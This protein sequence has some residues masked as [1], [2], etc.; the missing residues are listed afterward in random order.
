MNRLV[1]VLLALIVLAG[2]GAYLGGDSARGAVDASESAEELDPG[3]LRWLLRSRWWRQT[4]D[5]PAAPTLSDI[6]YDSLTVSWT[7]PESAVFEIVDYDVQYRTADA[8]GFVDWGHDGTATEATITGLAEDTEYRVRV[9]AVSDAGEGDWSETVGVTTLVRPPEFVEGESAEREVQENAAPG[10]AVGEP[11]TATVS[12]GAPRYSLEGPDAFAF[13]IDASSGQLLTR[14][15][16]TY[17]HEARD[18]YAVEVEARD[19]RGGTGRIAVRIE[20]LD[21]EEPPGKPGAPTVTAF[22]STGLQVTWTV[23]TNEG[24]ELSGYDVEYRA[25]GTEAYLDAEHEE[26]ATRA[27]I[28]GLARATLYEVRVRA[29]NDEGTGAW[30]DTAQ[31]RTPSA[32]GG[33]GGG[34]TSPPPPPPPPQNAAPI[35]TGARS[36]SVSENTLSVGRVMA[37]DPDNGDSISGYAITGGADRSRFSI[38]ATGNLRFTTARDFENPTD[39]FNASPRNAPRNNAYVLVVTATGGAGSRARTASRTITVAVSDTT[40][41]PATPAAPTIWSASSDS[42]T[43]RWTVPA[44]AGPL[45]RD[46]DVQYR[47][48]NSGNFDDWEHGGAGTVATI[49]GLAPSTSYQIQVLAR[50]DEGE[51]LWSLAGEGMTVDTVPTVLRVGLVSDAGPDATYKLGDKIQVAVTFSEA[52][53]VDATGGTPQI[54]LT[55]G[56]GSARQAAYLRGSDRTVLVFDYEVAATD[57]DTD[58]ASI[59][60]N[61]LTKNSGTIKKEDSSVDANLAHGALA[62]Q[63]GH[64]VDGSSS[65][66]TRPSSVVETFA[67]DQSSRH[68]D[69]LQACAYFRPD[70]ETCEFARLPYLGANTNRPTLND[71]MTRVL[72][73]HRWMGDN[74]RTMLAR[75]PPETL[76]LFRSITVVVIASDIRPA[77]YSAAYGAIYLDAAYLAL[78]AE[79]QASITD[80]E[81]YRSGFGS[82]LQFRMPWRMVRDNRWIL[83]HRDADRSRRIEDLTS[84]LG[85]LLFHELAHAADYMP[86]GEIAGLSL[87][88]KPYQVSDARLS[89]SV[90]SAYPLTSDVMKGLAKVSFHGTDSTATQ[91]ALEPDDLIGE[92]PPDG[93]TEYYAYSTVREDFATLFENIMTRFAFG[94]TADVGITDV[95]ASGERS[96]GVVAWGQRGRITDTAV[97]NRVR[98]AVRGVYA[99]DTA[100]RDAVEAYLNGLPA[101]KPLRAGETWGENVVLDVPAGQTVQGASEEALKDD[102]LRR[103]SIY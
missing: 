96:D 70:T 2:T 65:S 30:S 34:G 80:K 9:R 66:T 15:G 19:A 27:T 95:P 75:M 89:R 41:R 68:V 103:R 22:G 40:E 17:N 11:V 88:Q 26:T 48:G 73:S 84:F 97:I 90:S 56:T 42:L 1:G 86:V 16:I 13:V 99:S 43:A 55:I 38:D 39:I 21:V 85:F 78:T 52:V 60:A 20:V 18:S 6:S 91:R 25:R 72:V 44:N 67:F 50:S 36:F 98:A 79:Q 31:G 87:G 10:A 4:P 77:Y 83:A 32:G 33:G 59:G 81:D 94:I 37:T 12:R 7:G 28:T 58:G 62:D 29:V 47:V 45:V 24:P 35:F 61:A 102:L 92:F 64:A 51:S 3:I 101:P 5:Q 53:T 69:D 57:A 46:Y 93:A 71:V 100:I 82:D 14:Q 76:L 23:P 63:S 54:G 49:T 8:S 74:F